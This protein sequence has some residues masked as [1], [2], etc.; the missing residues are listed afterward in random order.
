MN[1]KCLQMH[2]LSWQTHIQPQCALDSNDGCPS[3]I[4]IKL[5]NSEPEQL[6]STKCLKKKKKQKKKHTVDINIALEIPAFLHA[7]A[8]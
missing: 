7:Q 1:A 8:N 6:Q 5:N 2:T 3:I 4:R